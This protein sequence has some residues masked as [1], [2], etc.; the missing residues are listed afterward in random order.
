MVR[1]VP[2]AGSMGWLLRVMGFHRAGLGA[3]EVAAR[4]P[5]SAVVLG[6]ADA[7]HPSSA[8]VSP[9]TSSITVS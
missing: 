6:A 5:N 9:M 3:G 8:Q 1:P 2:V 4:S 7:A